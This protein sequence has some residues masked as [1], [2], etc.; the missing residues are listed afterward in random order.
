MNSRIVVGL[1]F[2]VVA[3]VPPRVGAQDIS[4]RLA[5]QRADAALREIATELPAPASGGTQ[6][7][8]P[9]TAPPVPGSRREINVSLDGRLGFD[10]QTVALAAPAGVGIVR[11]R[12]SSVDLSVEYPFSDVSSVSLVVPWVD[13][14]ATLDSPIGSALRR[15]RGLGDIGIYFQHRYPEIARGTEL[16]ISVGLVTP[17]GKDAFSL[18]PNELPTGVGFYQPVARVTLR[19]MRLPLQ[20]YGAF[21]YGTAFSRNIG[22]TR[23]HLPDSYGGELGFYYAMGPEFIS[24]TSVSVSKVTSPFIDAPGSTVAYLSQAFH[25]QANL[26]TRLRASIDVGLTEDSTNAFAGL[27]LN[28]S[29]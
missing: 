9:G 18:A 17:T 24:Q 8:E 28:R 22:G 10:K 7:G 27:S 29:F 25:Y 16:G 26:V 14:R 3:M 13:Q 15:G 4:L 23:V 11:R 1:C 21:D 2:S 20:F 12:I 5:R 19:K 6:S